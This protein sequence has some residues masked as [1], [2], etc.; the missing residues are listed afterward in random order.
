[1]FPAEGR[2]LV[3]GRSQWPEARPPNFPSRPQVG[4]HHGI[5]LSA[6]IN[7]PAQESNFRKLRLWV[8]LRRHVAFVLKRQEKAFDEE[9]GRAISGDH[10]RAVLFASEQRVE[11]IH[12]QAA[13]VLLGIVAGATA[14]L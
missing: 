8:A 11:R 2:I 4:T 1:M 13:L 12:A 10:C 5:G 7:P 9:A 3:A 6:G 14:S